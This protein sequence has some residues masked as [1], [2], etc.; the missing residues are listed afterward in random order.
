MELIKLHID[1]NK[2]SNYIFFQDNAISDLL[3][4]ILQ[5]LIKKLMVTANKVNF[6]PLW[7]LNVT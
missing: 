3:K 4:R 5:N 7:K 1:Y 6:L 2:I